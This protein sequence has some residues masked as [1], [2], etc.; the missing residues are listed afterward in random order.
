[1]ADKF[2]DTLYNK[3]KEKSDSDAENSRVTVQFAEDGMIILGI[4]NPPGPC[5]SFT[6]DRDVI[7]SV[8]EKNFKIIPSEES[9]Y[10]RE[11]TK[12]LREYGETLIND[13]DRQLAISLGTSALADRRYPDIE[14]WVID[15]DK[16]PIL[17]IP[18]GPWLESLKDE[19]II[20]LATMN[21]AVFEIDSPDLFQWFLDRPGL[22]HEFIEPLN[23]LRFNSTINGSVLYFNLTYTIEN[24]QSA[25]HKT[26]EYL[27]EQRPSLFCRLLNY[28]E[29]DKDICLIP[30]FCLKD[31]DASLVR[32]AGRNQMVFE[33]IQDYVVKHKDPRLP[34]CRDMVETCKAA[35]GE[36]D[37]FNGSRRL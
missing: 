18:I 5:G 33:A 20:Y 30:E 7:N 26:V 6:I 13:I 19:E 17:K 16:G 35:R 3:N 15:N 32:V 34:M 29:G 37:V 23:A 24:D 25:L 14:A 21:W 31:L 36:S 4:S 12:I 10:R 22:Y 2:F 8:L 11:V 28:G 27:L 1:M 9:V